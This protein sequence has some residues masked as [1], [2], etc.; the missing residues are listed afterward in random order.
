M[1]RF[2]WVSSV[3]LLT[4]GANQAFGASVVSLSKKKRVAVIKPD[5][6]EVFA[7]GDD[8][9]IFEDEQ[10]VACGKVRR[11][12]KSGRAYV[13]IGTKAQFS[14]VKKGLIAKKEDGDT[15]TTSGEASSAS[16]A[17]QPFRVWI[18]YSGQVMAPT[19]F[20]K[21]SYA[22]SGTGITRSSLWDQGDDNGSALLGAKLGF[23][24]PFGTSAINTG[25]RFQKFTDVIVQSDYIDGNA[26]QYVETNQTGSSMGLWF[27]YNLMTMAIGSSSRID[28]YSGLD[29]D[30][31]TVNLKAT[32]LS[33]NSTDTVSGEFATATSKLTV[34]SLR[35]GSDFAFMFVPSFGANF[36]VD[37][38][39]PLAVISESFEASVS[40]SVA[41]SQTPD[42][43]QDEDLKDALGHTK[44]GFALGVNIGIALKF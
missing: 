3:L 15:S 34:A 18:D 32:H 25:F 16:G 24:I 26:D 12:T 43:K 28:F 38:L 17:K 11:V 33:D 27:D 14:K 1:S 21:I 29:I 30:M 42:L 40:D 44:A 23:A 22:K 6:G 2:L 35:V 7:K 31:S 10:Q 37:L 13:R 41:A 36:G 5:S 39:I 4:F 9:C 8:V 20:K 19:T